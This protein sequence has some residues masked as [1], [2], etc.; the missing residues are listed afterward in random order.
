MI[1]LLALSLV[2]AGPLFGKKQR[3]ETS[4]REEEPVVPDGAGVDAALLPAL[5]G[6]AEELQLEGLTRTTI[7]FTFTHDPM[8]L[9]LLDDTAASV[10]R[11][12]LAAD[13]RWRVTRLHDTWVATERSEERGAWTAGPG[14]YHFGSERCWRVGVRLSE[15]PA[16]HPW[17][18]GQKIAHLS[19][20]Q[21]SAPVWAHKLERGPCAGQRGVALVAKGRATALELFES[22]SGDATPGVQQALEKVPIELSNAAID[23]GLIRRRGYDPN[24]LSAPLPTGPT[25]PTLTK[26]SDGIELQATANPG[27]PGLTW[28]R[29]LVDGVPWQ[30]DV[31]REA[32]LEA[33]GW[34][35][36]PEERFWLQSRIPLA[37]SPFQATV[38]LWFQPSDGEPRL[39]WSGARTVEGPAPD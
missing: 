3:D 1:W 36:Q 20:N 14:G 30:D 28:L 25:E 33:P 29:I 38:E 39:M 7:R 19:M 6:Q 4:V 11:D 24:Q 31:V 2:H 32:T 13:P 16:D 9:D 15:A 12:H 26:R 35:H 37:A 21:P 8:V 22:G 18:V 10:L 27:E 34:S 5:V 17:T 23:D